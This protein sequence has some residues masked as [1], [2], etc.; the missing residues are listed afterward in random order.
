[1]QHADET[2]TGTYFQVSQCEPDVSLSWVSVEM[3]A[4]C[5]CCVTASSVSSGL[6]RT[7][8]SKSDPP[9]SHGFFF[10][11]LIRI[12]PAWFSISMTT[13][14]YLPLVCFILTL[15]FLIAKAF[16][17]LFM[18]CLLWGRSGRSWGF[19]VVSVHVLGN[20]FVWTGT[21]WRSPQ[22]WPFTSSAVYPLLSLQFRHLMP[23]RRDL[24][25][26]KLSDIP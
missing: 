12:K 1:M 24:T 3:L 11:S 9:A 6:V 17:L 13:L 23:S 22:C 18:T 26:Y 7:G 19:N 5:L 14:S 25:N 2:E 21:R 20:G 8:V 10:R 15:H 16:S 4:E